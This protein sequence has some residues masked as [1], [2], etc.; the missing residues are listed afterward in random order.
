[1]T[2]A[3]LAAIALCIVSSA[4][5]IIDIRRLRREARNG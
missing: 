3:I 2:A 5:S 1:M 4:V